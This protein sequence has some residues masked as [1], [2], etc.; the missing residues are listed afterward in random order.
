MQ[1]IDTKRIKRNGAST[2]IE[3]GEGEREVLSHSNFCSRIKDGIRNLI[4]VPPN[5]FGFV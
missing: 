2:K 3:I 5:Q 1:W 4:S